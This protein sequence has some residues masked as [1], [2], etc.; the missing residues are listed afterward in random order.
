[1]YSDFPEIKHLNG[2]I[3]VYSPDKLSYHLVY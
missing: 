2:I 3:L 1:M